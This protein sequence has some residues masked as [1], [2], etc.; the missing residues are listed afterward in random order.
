MANRDLER[1]KHWHRPSP[2]ADARGGR[3]RGTP[4]R[5]GRTSQTDRSAAGPHPSPREDHVRSRDER[6]NGPTLFDGIAVP[7]AEVPTPHATPITF[8]Q[9]FLDGY[10]GFVHADAYDGYNAVHNNV[11]HLGC[12]MHARRY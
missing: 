3:D 1:E 7:E 11:Q 8:P 5:G 4:R 10:R 9:R 2:A 6:V 12:W